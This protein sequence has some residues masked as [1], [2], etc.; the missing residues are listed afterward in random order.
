MRKSAELSYSRNDFKLLKYIEATS[1][2]WKFPRLKKTSFIPLALTPFN[3]IKGD[4]D[5]EYKTVH[6]I[7]HDYA[8]ER[9]W[10]Y[11]YRYLKVLQQYDGVIGPDFSCFIE[12]DNLRVVNLWNVYK[13]RVVDN[14][15]QS[16]GINVV[17]MVV[18][19]DICDLEWCLDGIPKNSNIAIS[20]HG[21][22]QNTQHKKIF[23]TCFEEVIRR[24]KP[25]KVIF[26]GIVP[27]ELEKYDSLL[28]R[29]DT[30]I[31]SYLKLQKTLQ[32]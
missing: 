8:F 32:M 14:F 25:T 16:F 23:T 3:Q 19:G 4:V 5:R 15:L 29:F 2:E 12:S 10:K 31:A 9:I 26:I 17:P 28:V 30:P 22:I 20:S 1:G 13:N 7:M 11:P 24:L 6:F 21:A 27:A 18:F